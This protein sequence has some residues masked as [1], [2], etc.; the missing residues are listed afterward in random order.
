[1]MRS[2]RVVA[3]AIGAFAARAG[4]QAKPPAPAAPDSVTIRIVST[5]LR[6]AVQIVQQYLDKPVI[7]SGANGAQ[8]SLE[9][10]KPVPRADVPRLL[11]GCGFW[12]LLLLYCPLLLWCS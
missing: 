12:L 8:V 5:E 6:T 7:F 4:G 10:P 11:R 2:S 1:M 3:V 9:T